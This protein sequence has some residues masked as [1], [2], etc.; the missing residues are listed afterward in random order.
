MSALDD[1]GGD[2]LELDQLLD[3]L[4][5]AQSPYYRSTNESSKEPLTE[6]LFRAA[7]KAGVQ[8]AYLFET[9]PP[10]RKIL[11]LRP[12]V[13][14]TE[15]KTR[16]EARAIHRRLWN[17][18][19]APFLVILLPNEI[20]V[21]TGFDFSL[22][23]EKKGLVKE[24]TDIVALTFK[25][26]REQLID[27]SSDSIDSGRIWETQSKYI[28]L[29]KRV[30]TQLLNNLRK[31]EQYLKDRNLDLQIIHA[32][33][34]K[35]VYIRYL[36]DRGILSKEWLAENNINL[37]TVLS[38][39]ATLVGLL[40]LTEVLENR[41]NGAVFPLPPDVET[42][43]GDEIVSLVAS[44][45][46]GDDPISGQLH[47]DFEAYDFSYIPVETLSSIYEQFLHSQGTGKKVGAVYTPEPVADYLLCELEE[48]KPLRSGMK[49][50]DP[51]CGSGI[52]LVLA[53]R[54]LI[55]L[56]LAKS[57]NSKLKPTKLRKILCES[58]YGIERNKEACSVAEFSLLLTL[59]NYIEPPDLHRNKQFK[60]PSLHNTQIFEC[61]FFDDESDFWK[62]N[63]KFD[64]IMG[65]PPW[66]EL[67][68]AIEH[69][70]LA[71]SWIRRNI[72]E[73][74][75]TGNRVCEAFSW[76]VV[77]L[78]APHG[79]VGLL[80]HAKSLFNHESEK[81]RKLFF[82]QHEVA[83][84]TNFSN[85]AYVLFGG[86]GE[87]PAAT[88]IYQ[89]ALPNVEKPGIIHYAPFV[90][91]QV[92]NRPW[93]REKKNPTWTITINSDE[94]QTLAPEDA[95]SGELSVW[96]LALWGSYRDKRV[97]KKIRRLLETTLEELSNE[98][99][100][101]LC[102]GL[103]MGDRSAWN[104][105]KNNNI[106]YLS[107]L[108]GCKRINSDLMVQ[109]KRRF[110]IPENALQEI[111]VEE[112]YTRKRSGKAGLKVA[113]APHII[114]STSY[115][116]Y[117]DEYFIIPHPKVGLSA[118]KDSAD[119]LRA[120]SVLLNSSILNYYLF[121]QSSSWG[122]DRNLVS[123]KDLKSVAVPIMSSEQISELSCLQRELEHLEKNELLADSYLQERLDDS[124][125]N[126]L[127]LPKSIGFMARDFTQVRLNL[128]KGKA[129]V[130]A[131]EKPQ[132]S[133]LLEYG[134]CLRDELDAF[135]EG[136]GLR[137]KVELIYSKQ[138]IVCSV[139]F[140]PSDAPIAIDVTVEKA[141]E[142]LSLLLN[143]IQEK[144]KQQ[145]SQ[146]VYVQRSLRI[147]EDS[148]VYICKSPRLID[149]TRTQALNDSDDIIAEIL[150]A[151]RG[152]REVI[153]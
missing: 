137:H 82:T 124:V 14:V 33:I 56:A 47:L 102:Q 84:I 54:K 70:E 42:I 7:K 24:I 2:F 4:G 85:L 98:K 9:S 11:P 35:Y 17:L 3:E 71:R 88:I 26:I 91:N 132:D 58:L 136:S 48:S 81:Y 49:I 13:Y 21:Y 69:E 8:G 104:S 67:K 97:L 62:Q 73:R 126:I 41:F 148:K 15:T 6:H 79:Y 63:K 119:H 31:L 50:L 115:C 53:Y 153:R 44:T 92:S 93:Q 55:E 110:S 100:W 130:F 150:S 80:I 52:F 106:E 114:I 95:E 30:D 94:I 68:P 146:W 27:F 32:L 45:F 29:D 10:E 128:N 61:D 89:K 103:Q 87:A 109:S 143:G 43:V 147:F 74:P 36:Y 116:V 141:Q 131:T 57:P 123:P 101:H 83:R 152:L 121:F 65:N 12:A 125:E 105:K 60:F 139:E 19:N 34:G 46:K 78:L 59:L 113:P 25:G 20:R 51:C 122:V 64:W 5:Y 151:N 22:K 39:K 145:F 135:T 1:A 120:I 28:N 23:N 77:D 107:D 127:E 118:S 37:D 40:H 149:W 142:D 112:L 75:A 138:L 108:K 76:R 134:F 96:K 18:G 66:I 16:D 99:R 117:S 111:P 140:I 129:V 72:E 144:A 133:D 38:R 86:R 90:A